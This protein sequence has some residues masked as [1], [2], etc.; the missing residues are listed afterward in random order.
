MLTNIMEDSYD[1]GNRKA[2]RQERLA[3]VF[4]SFQALKLDLLG[5]VQAFLTAFRTKAALGEAKS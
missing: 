1:D 2:K 3:I 4:E 5:K